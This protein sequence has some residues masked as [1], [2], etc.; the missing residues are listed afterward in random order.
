MRPTRT[1]HLT[2]Y[3]ESLPSFGVDVENANI[4][5]PDVVSFDVDVIVASAINNKKLVLSLLIA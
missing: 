5:E 2:E 3:C 1:R 4:V